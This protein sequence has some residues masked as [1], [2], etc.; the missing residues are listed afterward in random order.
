MQKRRDRNSP[1]E[2]VADCAPEGWLPGF[3]GRGLRKA[4]PQCLAHS[5]HSGIFSEAMHGRQLSLDRTLPCLAS[6]PSSQPMVA[7]LFQFLQVW[8]VSVY[9][10]CQPA[11]ENIQLQRPAGVWGGEGGGDRAEQPTHGASTPFTACDVRDPYPGLWPPWALESRDQVSVRQQELLSAQA[12]SP[13][14]LALSFS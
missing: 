8:N 12:P 7:A 2:W 14:L 13:C 10:Q 1:Q 4:S 11:L 5:R 9:H 3:L 6:P